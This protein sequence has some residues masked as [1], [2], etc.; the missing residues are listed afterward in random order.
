MPSNNMAYKLTSTEIKEG[1]LCTQLCSY[2]LRKEND[3]YTKYTKKNISL[4]T[5]HIFEDELRKYIPR[6]IYYKWYDYHI[7]IKGG[8]SYSINIC[9]SDYTFSN[10]VC[11]PANNIV[12][13]ITE[14]SSSREDNVLLIF[15]NNKQIAN[16]PS[17]SKELAISENDTL[18]YY[19]SENSKSGYH[20][21]NSLY[22]T[23][24]D[25]YIHN[26]LLYTKRNTAET[27]HLSC[28]A[29][30]KPYFI[31][32]TYDDNVEVI[33]LNANELDKNS[34][35]KYYT[36][37]ALDYTSIIHFKPTNY[38]LGANPRY[39]IYI[40]KGVSRLYDVYNK[41]DLLKTIGWIDP[42]R[43]GYHHFLIRP[44]DSSPYLY[45]PNRTHKSNKN[46]SLS[47]ITEYAG[48][49]P[50][51]TLNDAAHTHPEKTLIVFYGAYGLR[52]RIA[53]PYIYWAPL[54]KRGWRICFVLARGGG[55]NGDDWA[56][57]GR[58]TYHKSTINDVINAINFIKDTY[59]TTWS[60]TAIYSRSAGGIPAG[61]VTLMGLVGISFMEHP[62]VD[63]VETM[64]N[65]AL[66]LTAV[67]YGE[68]GNPAGVNLSEISPI[69]CMSCIG[70]FP[71]LQRPKVLLRTG[72]E[73]TQVYA[74]EPLKFA[75]RL[76]D[77]EFSEV[78]LGSEK[79][80]GH[81]Y[82]ADVWLKTRARDLALLDYWA[83][84]EKISSRDIKMALTHRNKNSRR[85][86]N[87]QRNKNKSKNM[88]GG[89][90]RTRRKASRR[91]RRKVGRKH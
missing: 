40:E 17:V 70:K 20:H 55:D 85:N 11:D 30:N 63:I 22:S 91:T 49:V 56:M 72:E 59:N 25:K 18:I 21:Y 64:G 88:E 27:L 81:F 54:L 76:R 19:V 69:N 24:Y 41:K 26:T 47:Y 74:Y 71:A 4:E 29:N 16:I 28:D 87:S 83:S 8:S 67:E 6:D 66:P 52:T 34:T 31:K 82:G 10:I 50:I 42:V 5:I 2:R 75:E 13:F 77:L 32:T 78:L 79:G 1:K 62:F 39:H 14:S 58:N 3:N 48:K 12:A 46:T 51:I 84:A 9:D 65:P 60:K 73:D 23:S 43:T 57:A 89:K 45:T 38:L 90:R 80:E 33:E 86:K 53:Y 68:F 61:I 37:E 44:I 7:T 36:G 15:K 35:S